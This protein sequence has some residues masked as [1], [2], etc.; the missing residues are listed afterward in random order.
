MAYAQMNQC[1]AIK[2]VW[3]K[4][5]QT[6]KASIH[7][8][9]MRHIQ[10]IQVQAMEGERGKAQLHHKGAQQALEVCQ[11]YTINMVMEEPRGT[12][13]EELIT[14]S[15]V[16]RRRT[17]SAS[18]HLNSTLITLR[19]IVLKVKEAET[20][21]E[22]VLILQDNLLQRDRSQMAAL[23]AR[24]NQTA[25]QHLLHPPPNHLQL[26]IASNQTKLQALN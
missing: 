24:T 19:D 3:K 11:I 12:S 13:L 21:T 6:D 17:E 1:I 9:K 14:I 23:L 10:P 25:D 18:K 4:V 22:I 2:E 16:S 5:A 7:R 8:L 15:K 20:E 26:A